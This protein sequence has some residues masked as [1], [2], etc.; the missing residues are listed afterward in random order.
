MSSHNVHGNYSLQDLLPLLP[1]TISIV[2]FEF[3]ISRRQ[4]IPLSCTKQG[5]SCSTWQTI[6]RH[7][8]EHELCS[9][10]QVIR[11]TF[12]SI[13]Y[14]CRRLWVLRLPSIL[15]FHRCRC[16]T[17]AQASQVDDACE[18]SLFC[19]T[20]LMTWM[21]VRFKRTPSNL[22]SLQYSAEMKGSVYKKFKILDSRFILG[23]KFFFWW[24]SWSLMRD[25]MQFTL[26]LPIWFSLISVVKNLVIFNYNLITKYWFIFKLNQSNN[27]PIPKN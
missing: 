9:V 18:A 21:F 10:S 26:K 2:K 14:S 7:L 19:K 15:A 12:N 17:A 8:E 3:R 16:H 5:R 6:N 11:S 24:N 23:F 13:S 20:M 22:L 25:C 27:K 4:N 1:V